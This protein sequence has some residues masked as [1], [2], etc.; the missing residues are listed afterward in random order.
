MPRPPLP[1]E[2]DL[3]CNVYIDESSQT[4]HRYLVLGGLVVPLSH[5][6]IFEA[7]IKAARDPLIA[8]TRATGEPRVIKWQKVN[9]YNVHAYKKVVDSFF[10]FE[11]R[12]NLPIKK[13][14]DICTLVVD[15]TKKDLKRSGDGD[16]EIGFNKE[17][18]FLCVPIIGNRFKNELFR[19]YP[20]R[21]TTKH[22]LKTALDIMN[23]GFNKYR[24]AGDKREWPYRRLRFEDPENCQ[25]LQVVDIFIGALAF[26]LNGHYDEPNANAGR[27]ELC[28]YI[29]TR[30]KIPN[31][32]ERTL[33][34]RRRLS[35]VHRDGLPYQ[36]PPKYTLRKDRVYA[37]R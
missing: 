3:F 24:K 11:M 17:I 28:D 5:A 29:L 15:T 36:Q 19:I 1:H 25:A 34:F 14:V 35:I 16:I 23:F 13:H 30:A 21:R 6:A 8:P 32:F 26:K 12:H 10:S 27:K 31:P 20:D 33:Y 22:D 7:D 2:A 4:K 18:Y 9:A 37:K